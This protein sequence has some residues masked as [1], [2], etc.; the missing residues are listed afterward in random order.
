MMGTSACCSTVGSTTPGMPSI[1]CLTS[2]ANCRRRVRLAGSL[3][4][5]KSLMATA[6]RVPESMWSMRCEIGWPICTAIPGILAKSFAQGGQQ[7]GLGPFGKPLFQRPVHVDGDFDF[8]PFD[9]DGVFGQ[10]RPALLPADR[11]HFGMRQ[12]DLFHLAA[13]LVRLLQVRAGQG[14]GPQRQRAFVELRQE[15]AAHVGDEAQGNDQHPRGGKADLVRMVD[16]PVEDW[17][18][19]VLRE[20]H[21]QRLPL[22]QHRLA[23]GKQNQAQRGGNGHGHGQRSQQGHDVGQGQ[24]HEQPAFHAGEEEQRREDQDHDDRG[25]EDRVADFHAGVEDDRNRTASFFGRK[26]MVLAQPPEDVFHVHDGV[27]HQGADGDGHAA[28]SHRVD[29]R[30]HRLEHDHRGQER[31]GN[32]HQRDE[33]CPQVA[34]EQ[35]HDDHH[36]DAAVAQGPFDVAHGRLDEVGLAEDVPLDGDSR[37]QRRLDFVERLVKPLGEFQRVDVRLLGDAQQDRRFSHGRAGAAFQ[38]RADLHHAQV[39]RRGWAPLCER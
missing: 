8:R 1:S 6:A 23:R 35:Q 21:H 24:G 20:P 17:P 4:G 33:T 9:A 28:Q 5:A 12:Q 27:V 11:H 10:L 29:R 34:Q 18:V 25:E 38:G 3:S 32:G 15:A 13:E 30:P 22:V 31:H 26:V 7:F 36:Q 2:L 39:G 19:D 14:I 37:R 16:H